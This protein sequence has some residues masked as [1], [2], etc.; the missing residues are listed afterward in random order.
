MDEA[1]ESE[2]IPIETEDQSIETEVN[3]AIG[4]E[5][6]G[7][8]EQEQ[9]Q[10][11]PDNGIAQQNSA[12]QPR[13]ELINQARLLHMTGN[14][15]NAIELYR[16]LAGL[17]PDDPNVVGEMGNVYYLQ[18]DWKRASQAY[19]DAAL[20]LHKLRMNEQIHYLYLV[21]HGL[22]PET[23]EKLREQLES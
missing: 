19:Y 5:T 6:D 18:G 2:S 20:R 16:E 15:N 9:I 23:A 12:Q 8:T 4:E 1:I 22:D 10:E 21:I 17:Y 7:E 11:D 13:S 3:Q 14:N